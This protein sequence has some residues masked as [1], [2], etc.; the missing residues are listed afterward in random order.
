MDDSDWCFGL[1]GLAVARV[2]GTIRLV[3]GRRR[4]LGDVT[5][6]TVVI[7]K[8][9][10]YGDMDAAQP[11]PY[12]IDELRQSGFDLAWTDEHLIGGWGRVARTERFLVPWVQAWLTRKQ[13]R[14]ATA[15]VAMFESEGHGLACFRVATGRR[16]PPLIIIGCWLADLARIGG[17]RRR[18]YRRLYRSVDGVVVFSSNQRDTLVELLDIEPRRV[19][20]VPFGVDLERLRSVSTSESGAVIAA[21]RD[22]GRDWPTLALAARESDWSVQLF[23]RPQQVEGLDLPDEIDFRGAVEAE[24]Y[25]SALAA[26]SVVVIPT[27][28]REYPTGQTV[29]LEAMA[30]GKACVVTDTPAMRDYV[31]HGVNG[32]L[33]P[34][35]DPEALRRAVDELLAD[36][37][38]RARLSEGAAAFSE[39]TGGAAAMW[40]RVGSVVEALAQGM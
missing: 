34:P 25:M 21:G 12:R 23:T 7:L 8:S 33:I 26:A 31:R 14:R 35:S 32:L 18:L 36:P 9:G 10:P 30:L 2:G 22:L 15:T 5:G 28:V 27:H 37:V 17:W 39:S 20:V 11:L 38:R 24:S 16:K 6:R 40:A 3:H 29:M 4:H 1:G 13:R 19:H